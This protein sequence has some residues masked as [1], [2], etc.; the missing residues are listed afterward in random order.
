MKWRSMLLEKKSDDMRECE[1]IKKKLTGHAER[2][3]EKGGRDGF[4]KSWQNWTIAIGE[5][6]GLRRKKWMSES[7]KN[8]CYIMQS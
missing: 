8:N 1:I 6:K 5:G 3:S 4:A 7:P 2:M